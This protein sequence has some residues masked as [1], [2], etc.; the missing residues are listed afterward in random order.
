MKTAIYDIRSQS[1]HYRDT[2]KALVGRRAIY[3]TYEG[4]R[5]EGVIEAG[6][7]VSGWRPIIRFADGRWGR[8]GDRVEVVNTEAA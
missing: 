4:E 6:S 1:A 3:T 2:T 5:M 7:Q 8:T